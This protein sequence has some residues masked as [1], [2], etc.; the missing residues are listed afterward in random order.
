MANTEMSTTLESF[1]QFPQCRKCGG[2]RVE[3]EFCQGGQHPFADTKCD[4]QMEHLH[5]KCKICGH[6]WLS[7]CMDGKRQRQ[8]A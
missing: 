3:T 6:T 5:R 1:R 4:I 7:R 8:A 2:Q